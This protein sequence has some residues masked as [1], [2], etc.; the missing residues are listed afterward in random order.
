MLGVVQRSTIFNEFTADEQEKYFS[1][2]EKAVSHHVDTLYYSVFLKDDD[3]NTTDTRI[4]GLLEQLRERKQVKLNNV[5]DDVQFMGLSVGAFGAAVS[6]GLYMNRLTYEENFDIFITDYIPN[7]DTPRIQVQLRTRSLVLDGLYGAIKKSYDALKQILDF[8]NLEIQEISENRIDYA[9]HTNCIQKP[10]E[11]FSDES[12]KAHLVTSYRELWKHV[13]ITSRKEEFF[14][15]DYIALGTRKSNNVFFRIYNK[16]K[17]VVQQNYKGFFFALW[18]ER[19][20]ISEYDQFVYEKAYE[21]KSFKTGCLVGRIEWYLKF[22]KDDELKAKLRDLLLK[23]NVKSDNNPYIEREIKGVLPPPTVVLNFEFETKRKFY[24]KLGSF[25]AR[26]KYKH[27]DE[28]ALRSLY[29]VL[30]LRREIVDKLCT[31]VVSFVEDR[32]DVES[33]EKDF[34]KRIRRVRIHDQPDKPTL[35]AWYS[36]SRNLDVRRTKRSF[37]G[38]LASLAMLHRGE[39]GDS[40]FSE[41]MWDALSQLNDNDI[42]ELDKGIFDKLTPKSYEN[43][44]KRKSRQLRSILKKM[45]SESDIEYQEIED[46]ELLIENAEN[47][48]QL[49]SEYE[50]LERDVNKKRREYL[51]ERRRAEKRGSGQYNYT[52]RENMKKRGDG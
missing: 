33:P 29:K 22:G 2:K 19:G 14:D 38:N 25:I 6:A 34:W 37:S 26:S 12:L 11:M 46:D 43:I 20:L 7:K 31:D 5:Q 27:N 51:E 10:M 36:Y 1:I 8:Y 17:E 9:F 48:K 3:V 30:S 42:A 41:D 23:C 52:W 45:N 40:T 21:M 50:E 49:R 44:Q 28:E 15:L 39:A 35:K 24:L 32:N 18:R 47:Q 4:N 16:A 13:W